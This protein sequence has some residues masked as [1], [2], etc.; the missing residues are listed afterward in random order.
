MVDAGL[1]QP[2]T[3]QRRGCASSVRSPSGRK[4]GYICQA[5]ALLGDYSGY[6]FS[7]K[8]FPLKYSLGLSL[9]R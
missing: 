1:D 8:I 3:A 2:R 4:A 9:I 7:S 6:G 5:S